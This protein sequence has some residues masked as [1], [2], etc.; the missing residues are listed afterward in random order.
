MHF[1]SRLRLALFLSPVF[2]TEKITDIDDSEGNI[3]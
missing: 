1:F 3:A 2:T